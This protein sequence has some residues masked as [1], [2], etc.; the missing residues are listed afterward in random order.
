MGRVLACLLVLVSCLPAPAGKKSDKKEDKKAAELK[1]AKEVAADFLSAGARRE[2]ASAEALL[3]A[4]FKKSLKEGSTSVSDRLSS[5]AI[6]S[7]KSWVVEKEEIAPDKDEALFRGKL[8][9]D[10]GEAEFSVR[11]VKEGDGGKWRV[12][13][14]SFG[15]WKARAESPKK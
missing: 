9:N 10:S 1:W 4:E 8:K 15:D 11:I 12:G 6:W 5:S 3:T 7:A 2:Y 14:F 13:F